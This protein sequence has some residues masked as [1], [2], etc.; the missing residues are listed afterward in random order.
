MPRISTNVMSHDLQIELTIMLITQ[1]KRS[2]IEEKILVVHEE[3]RKLLEEGFITEARLRTSVT[4][5]IL[6][7]KVNNK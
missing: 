7:K 3:V 5:P 2:L 1:G 4:N 6:V